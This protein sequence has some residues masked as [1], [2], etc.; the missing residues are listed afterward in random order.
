[1][2]LLHDLDGLHEGSDQFDQFD[3]SL[4]RPTHLDDSND[5]PMK[6]A[7]VSNND[8]N[9]T[10][11]ST[12]SGQHLVDSPGGAYPDPGSADHE[13]ILL[14]GTAPGDEDDHKSQSLNWSLSVSVTPAR[15]E[16]KNNNNNSHHGEKETL[17]STAGERDRERPARV[18]TGLWDMS[19]C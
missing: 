13:S 12:E 6:S 2:E 17:L 5:P 1:M 19:I 16:D 8:L 10:H 14:S 9:D 15:G 4:D 11:E 3:H 7:D 18:I